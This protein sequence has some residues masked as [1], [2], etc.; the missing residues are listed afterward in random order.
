MVN[1]LKNIKQYL[2]NDS[3]IL[4]INEN[5]LKPVNRFSVWT[6]FAIHVLHLKNYNLKNIIDFV[7]GSESISNLFSSLEHKETM[8]KFSDKLIKKI[9]HFNGNHPKKKILISEKLQKLF[10]QIHQDPNIQPKKQKEEINQKIL[11]EALQKKL[12]NEVK[13]IEKKPAKQSIDDAIP[14]VPKKP[15]PKPLLNELPA[16]ENN[17]DSKNDEEK[18]EKVEVEKKPDELSINDAISVVP[19]KLDPEPI[20]NELSTQG[21]NLEPKN[22]EEKLEKELVKVEQPAAPGLPDINEAMY[23]FQ[24]KP[25]P[26]PLIVELPCNE[27]FLEAWKKMGVIWV[28]P[29]YIKLALFSKAILPTGWTFKMEYEDDGDGYRLMLFNEK[30]L[31]QA[32]IFHSKRLQT[33][34]GK[35]LDLIEDDLA[36][37]P[38]IKKNNQLVAYPDCYELQQ[39]TYAEIKKAFESLGKIETIM[40]KDGRINHAF[41]IKFNKPINL[42]NAKNGIAINTAGSGIQETPF[43]LLGRSYQKFFLTPQMMVIDIE[44]LRL[45]DFNSPRLWR[46]LAALKHPICQQIKNEI[47]REPMIFRDWEQIYEKLDTLFSYD[48]RAKILLAYIRL[49]CRKIID[50]GFNISYKDDQHFEKASS[51]EIIKLY[52]ADAWKIV[53]D[54]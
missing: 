22:G 51:E 43:S 11:E 53:N 24:E 2:E 38:I 6:W 36:E 29:S 37:E 15:D 17:L 4:K 34:R 41:I 32:E 20:L 26:K 46:A 10:D 3:Y 19:K 14:V 35:I 23:V 48:Q 9:Q 25:E 52:T 12:Q 49:S 28:Q 45:T 31:V 42:K 27:A 39:C 44:G 18:L 30:G 50:R 54:P 47:G 8:L 33:I 7:A 13:E 40:Q 1:S 5:A 21:Q 16:N